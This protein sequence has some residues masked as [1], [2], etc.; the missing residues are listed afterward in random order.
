MIPI[1]FYIYLEITISNLL[2][3]IPADIVINRSK[4]LVVVP[5]VL[6]RGFRH[7]LVLMSADRAHSLFIEPL[8]NTVEMEGVAAIQAGYHPLLA[9]IHGTQAYHTVLNNNLPEMVLR[10][11]KRGFLFGSFLEKIP[12]FGPKLLYILFPILPP[13]F[14][15][16]VIN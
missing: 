11:L 12:N 9:I 1:L 15:D 10:L 3:K 8:E 13:T 2:W 14:I 4:T 7:H 16:G 5:L 6:M